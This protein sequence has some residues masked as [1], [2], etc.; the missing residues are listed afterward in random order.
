MTWTAAADAVMPGYARAA[1]ACPLATGTVTRR[2]GRPDRARTPRC[3]GVGVP[4][5]HEPGFLR[6][7]HL[8]HQVR[9][10]LATLGWPFDPGRDVA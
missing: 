7:L 9:A 2:T 10:D 4:R 8:L 6:P 3:R 1:A 5:Q